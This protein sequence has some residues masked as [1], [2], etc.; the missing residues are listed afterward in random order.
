MK[1]IETERL[2]LREFALEDLAALNRT[3]YADPDVRRYCGRVRCFE[4]LG[5]RLVYAVKS[6]VGEK[7]R[8]GRFRDEGFG[9]WTVRRREDNQL[10]RPV[11][12]NVYSSGGRSEFQFHRSRVK[13]RILFLVSDQ[14]GQR[15]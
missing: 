11:R 5:G 7:I 1:N 9:S 4:E 12:L 13:P 3:V 8:E 6:P 2:V 10:L 15:G 14:G